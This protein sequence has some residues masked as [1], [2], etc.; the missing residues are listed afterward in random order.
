[1]PYARQTLSQLQAGAASDIT[2]ALPGSDP[3]LRFANLNIIGTV[4]T[5]LA[6][7][8]YGY[9][10]WIA[11]QAVPFTATDEYLQGWAALKKVY[12][13]PAVQAGLASPGYVTFNGT[14]TT[15][16]P[17]GTTLVRGD[18][19]EFTSTATVTVSGGGTAAVP[20]VANA[21]PTGLTGAFGNTPVGVVMTLAQAIA[22]VTSTGT[23]TTAFTGGTDLETNDDLRSRT[24]T[25]YQQ[26][27]QGGALTDYQNWALAA[28]GVT[29][30]WAVANGFG[31][32]TVVIYVMLDVVEAAFAGFPQGTNGVATAEWRGTAATGDQLTT[33][34]Y[35][36]SLAPAPGLVYVAAPAANTLNFTVLGIPT[37]SQAAVQAAIAGVL[38]TQG[39]PGGTIPFRLIGAAVADVVP[40]TYF[41]M[42]PSVDIVSP[43]GEIP[44]LGTITW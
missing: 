2:A 8:H 40:G 32:G 38:A 31:V 41:T 37:A 27:P 33:A 23:V 34:N 12:L 25:A 19:V 20:A 36:F 44:V 42:S 29:R 22:G 30:A 14:P 5:N 21:D 9:Q 35:V 16:I 39:A 28:P 7:L 6:N 17:V 18:G 43:A 24:L 15:P 3:L 13:E 4:L 26:P 1:M 11:K 10:D